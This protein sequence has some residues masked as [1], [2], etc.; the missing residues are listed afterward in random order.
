MLSH[1]SSPVSFCSELLDSGGTLDLLH[2][3]SYVEV[4]MDSVGLYPTS[5]G[6]PWLPAS[7]AAL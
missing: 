6:H 3:S 1:L 2:G 7:P 5:E 4:S